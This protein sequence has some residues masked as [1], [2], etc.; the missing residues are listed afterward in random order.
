MLGTG[1]VPDV[2]DAGPAL[3]AAVVTVVDLYPNSILIEKSR[4]SLT[5]PAGTVT[6]VVSGGPAVDCAGCKMAPL[7]MSA[8][9]GPVNG[10]TVSLRLPI[11]SPTVCSTTG[12]GPGVESLAVLISAL[13]PLLIK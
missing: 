12:S 5:G 7:V 9:P 2:T 10:G 6:G 3:P 4:A 13:E 8:T 1:R 11:V